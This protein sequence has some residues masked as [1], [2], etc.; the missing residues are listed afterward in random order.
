[1]QINNMMNNNQG[2]DAALLRRQDSTHTEGMARL[3]LGQGERGNEV[4]YPMLPSQ[5]RLEGQMP[6][7]GQTM[8]DLYEHSPVEDNLGGGDQAFS[9]SSRDRELEDNHKENDSVGHGSSIGRVHSTTMLRNH[10]GTTFDSI[11]NPEKR[12]TLSRTESRME[13]DESEVVTIGHL[14]N[15]IRSLERQ[16]MEML[17]D[18]VNNEEAI[19]RCMRM[20]DMLKRA[21]IFKKDN[22]TLF[23]KSESSTEDNRRKEMSRFSIPAN[24]IPHFNLINTNYINKSAYDLR[25][26]QVS[27]SLVVFDTIKDFIYAFETAFS[28]NDTNIDDHWKTVLIQSMHKSKDIASKGWFER[29]FNKSTSFGNWNA[30]K[31]ALINKYQETKTQLDYTLE[32]ITLTHRYGEPIDQYT[33]RFWLQFNKSALEDSYLVVGVWF[34]NLQALVKPYMKKKLIMLRKLDQTIVTDPFLKDDNMT[35]IIEILDTFKNVMEADVRE[36]FKAN[37]TAAPT[38]R[39]REKESRLHEDHRDSQQEMPKRQKTGPKGRPQYATEE[40]NAIRGRIDFD[41]RICK[42][43][44]GKREFDHRCK[45]FYI[46]KKLPVPIALQSQKENHTGTFRTQ[47]SLF[48][49]SVRDG[50]DLHYNNNKESETKSYAPKLV[51]SPRKWEN[52]NKPSWSRDSRPKKELNMVVRSKMPKPDNKEKEQEEIHPAEN[53]MNEI[54]ENSTLSSYI[55]SIR[56]LEEQRA[57]DDAMNTEGRKYINVLKTTRKKAMVDDHNILTQNPHSPLSPFLYG[58]HRLM[59]K[60][61]SGADVSLMS[62]TLIRKLKINIK[63]CSLRTLTMADSHTSEVLGIT[64]PLTINY[65]GKKVVHAFYIMSS[66]PDHMQVVFGGG[67]IFDKLGIALT[68]VAYNVENNKV[69]HD[70]TV[71]DVQYQPNISNAGKEIEHAALMDALKPYFAKNRELDPRDLCTIPGSEV[72]IDTPEGEHCFRRQY[73]IADSMMPVFDE[74]VAEWKKNGYVIPAV[75]SPWNNPVTF[76]SKK[77]SD[78]KVKWRGCMDLRL[79]NNITKPMDNYSLSLPAQI[80]K[81]ANGCHIYTLLD[82]S[83]AYMRL[84]VKKSDRVKL[85]F[86]HRNECLMWRSACFGIKHMG[87]HFSRVMDIILGDLPNCYV[88][89]DDVILVTRENDMEKHFELVRTAIERLTAAKM[90]LNEEKAH[91]GKSCV[92]ILGQILSKQGRSVCPERLANVHEWT[93]PKTGKELQRTLGVF[94]YM[95]EHCPLASRVTW[96]LDALRNIGD[97]SVITWTHELKADFDSMKKILTSNIVLSPPDFSQPLFVACDAS[98]HAIGAVLFQNEEYQETGT[99]NKDGVKLIVKMKYIGFHS[100]ALTDCETR[101][102]VH[103]RELLAVVFALR[104]FHQ[105]LYA[106]HFTLQTD[107]RSLTYLFTQTPINIHFAQWFDTLLNYDFDV[108]HIKG[109]LNVL[110]DRL[111]RL[112]PSDHDLEEEENDAKHHKANEVRKLVFRPGK[113]FK[114]NHKEDV[115]DQEKMIAYVQASHKL[116]DKNYVTVPEEDR[117]K[118]LD[119]THKENGHFGADNIVKVIKNQN[120]SWPRILQDA[121]DCV[122]SCPLCVKF[123]ITKRGY[124]PQR[125]IYSYLPGDGYA[126]D[127]AGPFKSMNNIY[128]YL[129]ILVDVSTRFLILKPLVDKSAKSVAAAMIEA[130]AIV[131]L[132]RFFVVSDNGTEFANK[133]HDMLFQSMQ[134]EQRYSTPYHPQGNGLAEKYVQTTKRTLAKMIEGNTE[135]WY[136]YIPAIQLMINNKI[137]TKLQ[138]SPFSLMFARNMNEP[139]NYVDREGNEQKKEYMSNEELLK[140]IDYM[141]QIVFPAISDRH[142]LVDEAKHTAADKKNKQASFKEG[143]YVMAKVIDRDNAFS[144]AYEGPFLIER[145]T[146]GGTYLLRENST[147]MLVGRHYV[148]SELKEIIKDDIAIEDTLYEVEAIVG[149]NGKI[150]H[151]E[152]LV[153]WKNYDSTHNSWV[154]AKDFSDTDIINKYWK[155]VRKDHSGKIVNVDKEL[156]RKKFVN[157]LNKVNYKPSNRIK[158]IM[159]IPDVAENQKPNDLILE[160]NSTNKRARNKSS[161]SGRRTRR[162]SK[163]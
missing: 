87:S 13:V 5:A 14:E 109:V 117:K 135:D 28:L 148:P 144:P 24:Q 1:M 160:N 149:D 125:S 123:N 42:Y 124:L 129:L 67:D 3:N 44:K 56:K 106:R 132:P 138:S 50:K 162:R 22:D 86:R 141:S 84:K 150:G 78:G 102:P 58:N 98:A 26:E 156:K 17:N 51:K 76:V 23:S 96:R 68:G 111:S 151:R 77:S 8:R 63:P 47:R 143:D 121:I 46:L 10:V 161:Q 130:F 95:R 139:I 19:E 53:V 60:I 40:Y 43:C 145:V 62:E 74:T 158:T 39:E 131:G 120:I 35:K 38:K 88:Y 94:N 153:K 2:Q 55:R 90:I 36:L 61:D 159:E 155:Q 7:L 66:L 30:A 134:V 91:I 80:F 72:S 29:Y 140:R 113:T 112:F 70:D 25:K 83:S 119:D 108:V 163:L 33:E 118:L 133:L 59:A 15:Q 64:D 137:S 12:G 34:Q 65:N 71:D 81:E 4:E 27:N 126:M 20:M 122:S 100:R 32:L 128:S 52:H 104:K 16:M 18:P 110:P 146:N 85:S 115:V 107:H 97:K 99:N 57:K 73:P 116:S 101:W 154:K 105:F 136:L 114:P 79:L 69:I 45:E 21:L 127:L 152:Y 49:E 37:E 9:V 11:H 6:V 48:M 142:K 103:R 147:Q 54:K 92:V 89:I 82:C 93:Y 41:S 75:A 31:M 157:K